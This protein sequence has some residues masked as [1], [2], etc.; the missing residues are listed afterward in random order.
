LQQIRAL[1]AISLETA[2]IN[3][4]EQ[5]LRRL[6]VGFV[7]VTAKTNEKQEIFRGRRIDIKPIKVSELGA[8]PKDTVKNFQRANYPFK[9]M[10]YCSTSVGAVLSELHGRSNELIAVGK[11]KI[12][13]PFYLNQAG[14]HESVFEKYATSRDNFP[15][16]AF[17]RS[18]PTN[19]PSYRLIEGF[20]ATEFCCEVNEGQE[21]SYKISAAVATS[22]MDFDDQPYKSD[23]IGFHGIVYPS[24]AARANS[25]NLALRPKIVAECM[26]LVEADIISIVGIADDGRYLI[27]KQDT[28]NKFSTDGTIEWNGSPQSSSIFKDEDRATMTSENLWASGNGE[29]ISFKM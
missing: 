13:R 11:W 28:A 7:T 3:L 5:K 16:F 1:R 12:D 4:I 22:L 18:G 29:R 23:Q 10:F 6:L 24:L 14:F 21:W 27:Q 15:P 8:P 25:E 2:D 20:L 17:A 26:S 9:P 19:H